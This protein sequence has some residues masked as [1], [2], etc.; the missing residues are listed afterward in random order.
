[1]S[2]VFPDINLGLV[3]NA[4]SVGILLSGGLDSTLLLILLQL[5]SEKKNFKMTAFNVENNNGYEVHCRQILSHPFFKTVQ[6]VPNVPN[7]NDYSGIIRD[8]IAHVLKQEHLDL[9]YLGI[10]KNPDFFHEGKPVR[11]TA[12]ELAVYKK[13]RYP[14]LNLQKD[15]IVEIFCQIEDNLKLNILKLT[16]SCTEKASGQCGHCFQCVERKWAFE[17]NNRVDPCSEIE[18]NS[19]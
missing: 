10:N 6:F 3:S 4:T 19:L 9:V 13:L 7:S 15:R 2:F 14:F 11:R 16:H 8:G 12:E 17:K 18:S 1:M 5:E